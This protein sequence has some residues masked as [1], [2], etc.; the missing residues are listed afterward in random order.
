M[1]AEKALNENNKGKSNLHENHRARMREKL[2]KNGPEIFHDHELL[3]ML[4]FACDSRRNTNG[5]AHDLLERFGSLRGVLM[6]TPDALR[7]VS[8]VKDAATAHL[9]VVREIMKRVGEETLEMP[10]SL[11]SYEEIGKYFV[12]LFRLAAVEELHVA[13]F[14]SGMRMI[15]CV[16]VCEGTVNSAPVCMKAIIKEVMD[17]EASNVIIAHNHPG[18]KLIASP[19]DAITTRTISTVLSALDIKLLDHILVAE[20]KYTSILHTQYGL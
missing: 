16:R 6:A 2:L 9:L 1:V 18:G 5:T 13:M 4:L 8:N 19:E 10:S 7:G 17:K 12:E 11:N 15:G 20:D 3:E 14:D